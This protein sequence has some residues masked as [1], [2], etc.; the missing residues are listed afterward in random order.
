MAEQIIMPKLGLTMKD[1]KI[2]Q[3]CKAEGDH[4][5]KG[6]ILF[7][8][9][10]EKIT[11]EVEA[12]ASGI[13]GKILVPENET[14]AVTAPVALII[15]EGESVD[16]PSPAAKAQM[17]LEAAAPPRKAGGKVKASP[18]AKKIAE[19]HGID[20]SMIEGTGPEGRITKEDVL[21]FLEVKA[22]APAIEMEAVASSQE[23][24]I[25]EVVI[26]LDGMR[27]TIA[28]R[29]TESWQ[30]TPHFMLTVEADVSEMVSLRGQWLPLIEKM[31]GERITYTDFLIK[32]VAMTLKKHPGVNA[33]WTDKGI[34]MNQHVNIGMAVAVKNGLIV[35]VIKDAGGKSLSEITAMRADISRRA[36]EGKIMPDE[37][38]GGSVTITNLG[39]FGIDHFIAVINPPESSILSVGRMMDKVLVVEGEIKI[40][41]TMTFVLSV[42]HRVVDG[43]T[44]S[45]FLRDIKEMIE[46]P[47]L[48]S[49]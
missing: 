10:T 36:S 21:K 2:I 7:I 22:K 19:E 20:I 43:A 46:N 3:W 42:D 32:I 18:L 4:V 44:G 24:P 30:T 31:T 14:V 35:P 49:L 13:L 37:M 27:R 25:E 48:M 47:V 29:M 16:A 40:R 12:T 6:E 23:K 11:Y 1:G 41:P 45:R 15:Q 28:K 33:S 5:S 17:P 39:M 34:R 9:E 26:P 8:V 38:T